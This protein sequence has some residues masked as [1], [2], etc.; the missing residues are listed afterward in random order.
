MVLRPRQQKQRH[1]LPISRRLSSTSPLRLA[2]L[3]QL[4]LLLGA[5]TTTML[6]GATAT[7]TATTIGRRAAYARRHRS[8]AAAPVVGFLRPSV[9]QLPS[10]VRRLASVP[11]SAVGSSS[12]SRR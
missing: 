2:L 8:A 9:L 1:R 5:T 12:N 11:S 4:L 3:F 7:A 6:R 10:P